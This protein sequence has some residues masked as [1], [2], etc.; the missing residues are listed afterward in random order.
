MRVLE[1]IFKLDYLAA[2][3][4]RSGVDAPA[5]CPINQRFQLACLCKRV[6]PEIFFLL[7]AEKSPQLPAVGSIFPPKAEHLLTAPHAFWVSSKRN[8]R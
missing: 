6:E 3:F 8:R 5:Y 4:H 7:W 1:L 2:R